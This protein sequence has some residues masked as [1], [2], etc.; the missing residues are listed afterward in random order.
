MNEK[1]TYTLDDFRMN[2]YAY[3][4]ISALGYARS[5][6]AYDINHS[7]ILTEL[8]H[9]AGRYC[10]SFASDLFIDWQRVLETIDEAEPGMKR[11]FLFGFRQQG[12][13][14]DSFIFSRFNS[15]GY[16]AKLE[17][18]SLWRLDIKTDDDGSIVMTLGRVF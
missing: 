10:E 2:T 13:D 14:H 11:T 16:S 7:S 12:V 4:P 5:N 1:K 8:I 17:Y 6:G 15:Y 9:E 18:R 3:K